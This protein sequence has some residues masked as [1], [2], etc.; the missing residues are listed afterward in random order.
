[1]YTYIHKCVK[2]PLAIGWSGAC[3]DFLVLCVGVGVGVDAVVGVGVDAGVHA[4]VGAGLSVG[5]DV[6]KSRGGGD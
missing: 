5:F 4:G 6:G 2:W 3:V 1:M